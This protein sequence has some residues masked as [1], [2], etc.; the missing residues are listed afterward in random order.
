VPSA[1]YPSS[2]EIE[3]QL[4]FEQPTLSNTTGKLDI[5]KHDGTTLLTEQLDITSEI[6]RE[7]L[8][9][10]LAQKESRVSTVK[11][12]QR[13]CAL[14]EMLKPGSGICDSG[15]KTTDKKMNP[16]A[17]LN[18]V[19]ILLAGGFADED[20]NS[21]TEPN[22]SDS[23]Q[24]STVDEALYKQLVEKYQELIDTFG[25]D[26][27]SENGKKVP[28]G[29]LNK[30]EPLVLPVKGLNIPFAD[31][32]LQDGDTVIVERL[33]L[34]LVTVVGLVNKPG[35]F[36]YPPD[37]RYNLMQALGFAGGFNQAANPRYATVYRM[38]PDRTIV[39]AIFP[40]VK[41]SRMTEA[42]GILIKPGDIV[43]VEH[44]PRTRKNVFLDKVFRINFG[45]YVPLGD[46]WGD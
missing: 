41:G 9:R 19:Q 8:L 31:V 45:A 34:P 24:D 40:L 2:N 16:D 36:P 22:W 5:I 21:N 46:L 38:K 37:A 33:E 30:H 23:E 10:K 42:L 25:Q 14:A 18:M 26:K 29:K 20:I 13:L 1:R 7:V 4:T 35:N 32:A 12:N 6:E 11:V 39:H 28:F 3:V 44:T 17:E 43:A 27:K 15:N